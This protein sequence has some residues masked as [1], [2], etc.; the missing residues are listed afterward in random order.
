MYLLNMSKKVSYGSLEE[1]KALDAKR[2]FYSLPPEA[3]CLRRE[4]ILQAF[5]E[6][7]PE[8]RITLKL[9]KKYNE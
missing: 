5:E 1:L 8:G 7:D 9:S 4:G 2:E 3:V 6:Y